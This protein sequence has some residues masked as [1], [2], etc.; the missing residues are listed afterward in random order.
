VVNHKSGPVLEVTNYRAF[1]GKL[2]G[3]SSQAA[4][5]LSNRFQFMGKEKQ[6]KEFSDGSG[7][8]WSDFGARMYDAQIGRWFNI[9]PLADQM[10]RHSPY[11]F[12]FDN[13][14]RF[15]DPDGMGPTDVILSGSERQKA[16]TELQASVQGSLTL[17]MDDKGK[18]TYTQNIEAPT[19]NNVTPTAGAAALMGAIDD[20]SIVVNV[21]ATDKITS[22]SGNTF[23]GG[24]FQGNTVT[25]APVVTVETNQLVNPNVTKKMDDYYNKPG[26]TILH[27]VVE[28]YV[29][30]QNAKASGA[31][32]G[33]SNATPKAYD[34]AHAAASVVAPQ[35]GPIYR[36]TY[37]TQGNV[38]SAP[39]TN[40]GKREWIVKEGKR[41]PLIIQTYPQQ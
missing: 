27:E 39:Y 21:E 25:P 17:A 2:A 16:F 5:K 32:A 23:T 15:I 11:N 18:V 14:I 9:D 29:G 7:L 3:I 26:A 8:E 22:P 33:T 19:G 36:K 37:D 38:I 10:R 28:S 4:G 34:D 40:F 35:S 41:E 30:G 31:S 20:H 13:P 12:A 1:G 6:D 24:S